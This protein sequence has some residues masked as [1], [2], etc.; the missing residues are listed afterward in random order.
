MNFRGQFHQPS[1]NSFCVRRSQKGQ[2]LKTD[3]LTVFFALLES[4]SVKSALEML[5]KLT[6]ALTFLNNMKQLVPIIECRLLKEYQ[7]NSVIIS[8]L[9]KNILAVLILTLL[10]QAC[11]KL[12]RGSFNLAHTAQI[13][14]LLPYLLN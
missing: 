5:V 10:Y 11:T 6:S 14:V 4:A 2:K 3:K 12:T 1:T 8:K 13:F 9:T 7:G